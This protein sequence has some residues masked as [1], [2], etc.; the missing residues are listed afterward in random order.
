[1]GRRWHAVPVSLVLLIAGATSGWAEGE[2]VVF[3]ETDRAFIQSMGPWPAAFKP[4]P[5]NRFSG[6]PKAIEFGQSLF[7]DGRLSKDGTV[8]CASCHDP[9]NHFIDGRDRSVGASRV[10]RNAPSLNNIHPNRWFGWA[11]RSDTLWGQ[12]VHPILD[13]KE[14]SASAALV[15]S[16]VREETDLRTRYL[17]VAGT[18]PPDAPDE[19]I[20]VNLAKFLAAYQETLTT[21]RTRFDGFRDRLISG[22]P[23][24]V[25][26]Y[27]PS[28]RRGLKLFVGKGNCV[29]CH[30]GPTLSNGEFH[31]LGLPHFA[32]GVRV[33]QGRF[34]G[35]R[36]L[37]KSRYNRLGPFSDEPKTSAEKSPATYVRLDQRNWGEFKTPSL[38]NVANT[39]PYMHNGGLAG[40]RD[41]INHYS[42]LNLERLHVDG[43]SILQPLKLNE[44]E[45]MDL[46]AFLESLSSGP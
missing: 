19:Q 35:I 13:Q 15:A 17:G 3:S 24:P 12:S 46:I 44:R 39:A 10:D 6:N 9:Q 27:S 25:A 21:P 41:V 32:E 37:K 7:S 30:F 33:D 31:F 4:D 18:S 5:S 42:D 2:D 29:I 43:E 11:G 23:T 40:L 20:I 22:K 38:R 8:S 34:G 28:E 36:L 26:D 45:I 14:L 16:R 1:M